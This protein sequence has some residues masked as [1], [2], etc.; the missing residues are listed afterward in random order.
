M[1]KRLVSEGRETR[2][3][4]REKE[5]KEVAVTVR[6][7]EVFLTITIRIEMKETRDTGE[8][9]LHDVCVFYAL[10]E[11]SLRFVVFVLI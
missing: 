6:D 3:K 8:K 10:N 7:R 1:V 4:E 2:E 9:R 5:K 11:V